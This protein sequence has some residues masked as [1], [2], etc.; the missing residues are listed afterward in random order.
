MNKLKIFLSIGNVYKENSQND[1]EHYTTYGVSVPI[2][3]LTNTLT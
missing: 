3:P 1:I 2:E